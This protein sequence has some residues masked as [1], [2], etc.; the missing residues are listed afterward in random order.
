MADYVHPQDDLRAVKANQEVRFMKQSLLANGAWVLLLA[1]GGGL[2][3]KADHLTGGAVGLSNPTSVITFD[4]LGNLQNQVITNQFAAFG[5]TFEN[6]GWDEATNGQS[7]STGFAGADLVNG[8]APFP[9]AE[10]IVIS[11]NTPVV[12]AAF[13]TVDQGGTFTLN[14]YLGGTSGTLIDSFNITIPG[15]PGAGFI[16]FAKEE[17]DTIQIIPMG[18]SA[19]SIDT[20]QLQLNAV[21]EPTSIM[22]LATIT[23]GIG[24][25]DRRNRRRPRR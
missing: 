18:Q 1:I 21:P 12:A 19:I 16:G 2:P 3:S 13:A 23:I 14:A 5:A 6:L 25:L 15:N 17:F 24:I 9:T 4:E 10:P 11:F 22:L 20:V 8:F 7:G